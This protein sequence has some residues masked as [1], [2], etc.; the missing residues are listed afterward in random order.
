MPQPFT[1]LVVCIGNV[2]RSPLA[3]RLLRERLRE[4]LGELSEAVVVESAGTRALA[5]RPMDAMAAQELGRLGL[6][7]E[8][9]RARQ[10]TERMANDAGLVL[11]ATKELR[12]R[13]LEDAPGA[14]RRAFTITEFAALADG[15]SAD[16]PRELVADAAQRRS[17]AQVED[18][19]IPDPIG[20]GPD[21]HRKAADLVD[22]RVTPIAAAI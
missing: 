20:A 6:T 3:E 17:L 8:D 1:V 14:L 11:T 5:G 19:D 21:V 16:S 4:Q 10:L 15:V 12:S 22:A 9:F 18:Y 7:N 13:V 2:C